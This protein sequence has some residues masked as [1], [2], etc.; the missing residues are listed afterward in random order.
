[1]AE[2][3]TIARPYAD[4]LFDAAQAADPV[5]WGAQLDALAAVAADP[6]M[7]AFAANPEASH[8]QVY[9]TITGVA[10]SSEPVIA[11][12]GNFLRTVIGNGRL[13]VLPEIATQYRQLL[14][15]HRGVADATIY[16]AFPMSD[17]DT[18][19][20]VASLEQRFKRKLRATVVVSPE[21]IGGIRVEVGD[22]V[23]DTSVQGQL[24]RMKVALTA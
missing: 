2:L 21:L 5:A 22:E 24:E 14:N 12:I 8:D 4:A 11:G 3:A 18:A 6:A 9:Q 10:L 20:V 1:M 7:Q 15:Q 19:S 13:V 23:L 16:S 17:A